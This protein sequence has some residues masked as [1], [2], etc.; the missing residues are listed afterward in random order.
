MDLNIKKQINKLNSEKYKQY[1]YFSTGETKGTSDT[2]DNLLTSLQKINTDLVSLSLSVE[3]TKSGNDSAP[4]L[5]ELRELL[6]HAVDAKNKINKST[7]K[8]FLPSELDEIK[9]V[10]GTIQQFLESIESYKEFNLENQQLLKEKLMDEFNDAQIAYNQDR[11]A[12]NYF[13]AKDIE[14]ELQEVNKGIQEDEKL[15]RSKTFR[16]YFNTVK[17]VEQLIQNKLLRNEG[18]TEYAKQIGGGYN[19]MHSHQGTEF[20]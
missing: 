12:E 15:S 20:I 17:E 5:S 10:Y 4:S 8:T 16:L 9:K 11:S 1:G 3:R 19:W 18:V 2:F 6:N 7:F 14:Y 13:I